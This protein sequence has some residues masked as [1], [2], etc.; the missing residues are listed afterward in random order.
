MRW[1]P[2]EWGAA[3]GPGQGRES[4]GAEEGPGR[5]RGSRAP[6]REGPELEQVP[7]GVLPPA[8]SRPGALGP[9]WPGPGTP[10]VCG[11]IC[12]GKGRGRAVTDRGQERVGS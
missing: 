10:S 4:S 7:G 1:A 6:G 12:W 9:L 3:L 2:D 11:Q 5:P 8:A